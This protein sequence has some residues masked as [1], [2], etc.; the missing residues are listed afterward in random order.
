MRPHATATPRPTPVTPGTRVVTLRVHSLSTLLGSGVWMSTAQR[1]A[2]NAV[3]IEVGPDQWDA[4]RLDR[5]GLNAALARLIEQRLE[6]ILNPRHRTHG[7][8]VEAH[9]A[10]GFFKWG[11]WEVGVIRIRELAEAQGAA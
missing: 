8:S 1:D 6:P 10:Q 7:T 9:P 5:T 3:R 11:V 4:L 2:V